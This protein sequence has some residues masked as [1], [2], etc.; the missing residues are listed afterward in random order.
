MTKGIGIWVFTLAAWMAAL[1]TFGQDDYA[2]ED[3]T[4]PD[5]RTTIGV[6]LTP[7]VVIAMNGLPMNPRWSLYYKR[8]VQPWKKYRVQANFEVLENY[9][10]LRENTPL[11]WSD[12]TITYLLHDRFH[13]NA[14]L[15][16]G[17]EYFKPNQK[18]TMV[19]GFDAFV[20]IAVRNDVAFT[21]PYAWSIEDQ[22]WIP[23]PTVSPWSR[24]GEVIY[25]YV[26]LDFSIG[27]K[28]HVR[29][30][31][32]FTIQWTP[33]LMYLRPFSERYSSPEARTDAPQSAIEF[34]LRGIEVFFQY[35]F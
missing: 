4:M 10:S 6:N 7:M 17:V 19:Y 5:E 15:R 29:D 2:P 18:F 34:R 26:G 28:V 24:E 3:L 21:T 1:A 12:S 11:E 14:D 31:V 32:Y 23:S 9:Q 33:E 35:M 22:F 8:Q 16:F 13:Y 30:H 27:Q 20:G 25:G